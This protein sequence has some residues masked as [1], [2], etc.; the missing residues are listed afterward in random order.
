MN[1]LAVKFNRQDQP[2]FFKELQQKVNKYFKEKKISKHA[3]LNM[4]V[5]T[6]FM[7]CLYFVPLAI[8]ISGVVSSLWVSLTLWVLMSMGMSGIGLSVMHDANH[9]SYS[10]NQTVNKVLGYLSN[11]IGGY[12]VNWKIQHNVLHHSFTNVDGFDEDINKPGIIRFSPTQKRKSFFRFQAFYAPLLYG[13]M[14]LYWFTS[15]DFEQVVR[16][17]KKNLL[18]SQGLTLK[19]ALAHLVFNKTWYVALTLIL[20]IIMVQLPWWQTLLGFVLMHIICG[21]VLALIF[22]PAHVIEET[23]FYLPAENGTVENSWAIHQMKTTSN[24]AN[25]SV[26]FSWLI[27]GLNYQIE[28][29]LFPNIC[30]VHYRKISS[31]VKETAEKYNLP[32]YHHETFFAAVKS[33][34][35]LL[36]Q[37]GTGKYDQKLANA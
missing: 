24:F 29:H 7:L 26:I 20:P 5:K 18:A 32:Y 34:F 10:T 8:L 28:H 23:D 27:G 37:L 14:T 33:H 35:T 12:H 6:A 25:G 16:Y 2:E 31:I 21:L 17:K 22:Q 15:K 19:K 13:V 4:K 30:H 9:G 36:N 1:K 3:N 11:F